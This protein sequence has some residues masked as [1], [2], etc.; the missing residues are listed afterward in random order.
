VALRAD[1]PEVMKLTASFALGLLLLGGVNAAYAHEGGEHGSSRG[2][3]ARGLVFDG[4][5]PARAHGPCMEGFELRLPGNRIGC[6]HGPDPAPPGRDV[7]EPRPLGDIAALSTGDPGDGG[8][9]GAGDVLCVGDGV[10]GNR[11]QAVYAYP[12]DGADNYRAVAP[13]IRQWAAQADGVINAS[14]AETGGVR[15]VRYVTDV[16]CQLDVAKVALSP[17]GVANLAG[18]AADLQAQGLDRADRKYL[19]WVDTYVYCGVATVKPDDQPRQTNANNGD[20]RPGMVARIDR[21]CWGNPSSSAETHELTHILGGVQP[22]APHG[23]WNYHC[24]DESELMCYDDDSTADGYVGSHGVLVPLTYPCGKAHERL[25]DC[26]HDDYFSTSPSAE[27]WLYQHWNVADS[28]FLTSEGPPVSP[29]T[30]APRPTKPRPRVAGQLGRKVPVRLTW[31]SRAADVAGYWLWKSVDGRRWR[32]VNRRDLWSDTADVRVRRGHSYRF[33]VH[34]FDAA[35]NASPAAVGYRF[36]VRVFQES[37]RA[38]SYRGSW[39]HVYRPAASAEHVSLSRSSSGR[40]RLRFYGKA[41]AWVSPTSTDGGSASV[42][43]DGNYVQRVDLT[44]AEPRERRVVF[45]HRFKR[46]GWHRIAV[47]PIEGPVE[48]P[49]DAFVVLR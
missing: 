2:A 1:D 38:V 33:L 7:R 24:S 42:F 49:V 25:L 16:A 26:G 23:T 35:G 28:S 3:P 40:S 41:I 29:D 30:T 48:V 34:A 47:K 31:S 14:A 27:S 17:E 44:S 13:Y 11:I 45:W 19:V 37:N 21:G 18:T 10:D 9:A 43:V 32:Y 22:T 8:G 4:L 39:A 12:A 46:L 6:T 20:G 5:T 15:H 36:R